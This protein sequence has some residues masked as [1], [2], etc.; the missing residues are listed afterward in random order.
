MS[1]I[2]G[3]WES[4]PKRHTRDITEWTIGGVFLGGGEGSQMRMNQEGTLQSF[5]P[6]RHL[7]WLTWSSSR[8]LEDDSSIVAGGRWLAGCLADFIGCVVLAKYRSLSWLRG[9]VGVL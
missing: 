5:C 4:H 1:G 2:F 7:S 9:E 3:S 8:L 6:H